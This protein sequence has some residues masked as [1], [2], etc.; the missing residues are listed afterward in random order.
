MVATRKRKIAILPLMALGLALVYLCNFMALVGSRQQQ[1][2]VVM[3]PIHPTID[4][5]ASQAVVSRKDN[6]QKGVSWKAHAVEPTPPTT[7]NVNSSSTTTTRLRNNNASDDDESENHPII[8]LCFVTCEFSK[9]VEDADR[10]P[11]LEPIMIRNPPR[12]FVFTNLPTLLLHSNNN[13]NSN[14]TTTTTTTTT[15]WKLIL[16]THLPY[17]RMITQ[18]RWGKFLGWKHEALQDCQV[19]F[20]GDAYF[21]NPINET[22]WQYMARQILHHNTNVGLMQAK[23][24]GSNQKPVKGPVV[25]LRKNA[26]MG[27]VS[28]AMANKTIEW[29]RNQSDYKPLGQTPVYKNALFGYNPQNPH[30]RTMVVDFWKEYSKERASWRD[31]P[32]WAYF[33]SKHQMTPLKFPKNIVPPPMGPGGERGH[34]DHLYVLPEND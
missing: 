34:N 25:E 24:M 16:Q 6:S 13:S 9:S 29:L 31:Q 7:T 33:L 21:L 27:K 23:Q 10:L 5:H 1:P 28:W 32:Y 12:H 18:S 26:R 20:Y 2:V 4:E 15:G 14:N 19:I 8:Q 17:Q 3:D 22:A 30:F 11:Q